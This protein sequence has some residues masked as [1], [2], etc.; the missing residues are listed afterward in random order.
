MPILEVRIE[1]FKYFAAAQPS[2]GNISLDVEPGE[3]II[4][5]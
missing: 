1:S 5:T 4:L 2:L 3:F